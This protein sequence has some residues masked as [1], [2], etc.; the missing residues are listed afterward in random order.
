[1]CHCVCIFFPN[2]LISSVMISLPPQLWLLLYFLMFIHKQTLEISFYTF[3][4]LQVISLCSVFMTAIL[5]MM[6]SIMFCFCS[7][8]LETLASMTR[9]LSTMPEVGVNL[10]KMSI[11]LIGCMSAQMNPLHSCMEGNFSSNLLWMHG[12]TLSRASYHGSDITKQGFVL[13]NSMGVWMLPMLGIILVMLA[14]LHSAFKPYW[15]STEHVLIL[16][17][18]IQYYTSQ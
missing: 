3:G 6:L 7:F 17:G 15:K 14:S 11:I 2:T 12:H 9:C 1:M 16:P 18:F 5:H 13:P 10:P 8:H 4:T